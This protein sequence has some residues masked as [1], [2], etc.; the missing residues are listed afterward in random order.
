[1]AETKQKSPKRYVGRSMKRVEDPR[2]IKGIATYVDDVKLP[3]LLHAEFV[4]SPHAHAK[5]REIKTD[6]AKKLP[7]VLGVLCL[8]GCFSTSPLT[9]TYCV[10]YRPRADT[11]GLAETTG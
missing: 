9:S 7:G 10:G 11:W 2:L 8:S 4:R 3:N 6:A 1:M 5:I